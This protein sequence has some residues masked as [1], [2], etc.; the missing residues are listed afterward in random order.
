[1]VYG[2][3]DKL[4]VGISSRA[5]FDLTMENALFEEEGVESYRNYQ[6]AHENEILRPGP[7]FALVK[8][9]LDLNKLPGGRDRVEVIVMSRNSPDT[10]LRVFNA[11]RFYDLAI[12]RAVLVSGASL[13]HSK[14]ICFYPPMK[15]T[16]RRP[17]IRGSQRES[18]VKILFMST[19]KRLETVRSKSLLMRTRFFFQTNRN[20]FIRRRGLRHLKKTK[21]KMRNCR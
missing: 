2:L 6:I 10:S 11:I 3:E 5:L 18:Y 13:A 19:K 21:G 15:K 4:V 16:C 8:A 1:M 12:T 14:R 17:W 20:A 9:L 7:G